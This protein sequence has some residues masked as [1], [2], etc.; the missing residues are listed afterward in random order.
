MSVFQLDLDLLETAKD[1]YIKSAEAL[2]ADIETSNTVVSNTTTE[3]YEGEDGE[4]FRSG[5]GNFVNKDFTDIGDTVK[6][7]GTALESGLEEGKKC[8]KICNDFLYTL[9]GTASGTTVEEMKGI[10][11]CDQSIITELKGF[12]STALEHNEAVRLGSLELDSIL[13]K[14]QMVSLN[15][16]QYTEII[17]E[18]CKKVERL[19]DHSAELTTYATAA[20]DADSGLNSYLS[21]CMPLGCL[22]A[23]L[24]ADLLSPQARQVLDTI[25]KPEGEW[26]EEDR[27]NLE[28]NLWILTE[29]GEITELEKIAGAIAASENDIAHT[30]VGYCVMGILLDYAERNCNK[31]I[32]D[33]L[34][35]SML[36]T[37]VVSIQPDMHT[38]TTFTTY[39]YELSFDSEIVSGILG[40]LDPEENGLAYYSLQR[41]SKYAG[42]DE[43]A[44]TVAGIYPEAPEVDYEISFEEIDGKMVSVI[45][46]G[47]EE[48]KL[49]SV[50]MNEI[51]GEEGKA[52]M[53]NEKGFSDEQ[54]VLFMSN[55]YTDED[56]VFVGDLASA[57]TD[58]DYKELFQNDPNKLSIHAGI[59]LHNY[60]LMLENGDIKYDEN[61]TITNQT[62][63]TLQE[64]IN[65]M[66][67]REAS[68]VVIEEQ[69]NGK[70]REVWIE[71]YRKGYL[72][73]MVIAGETQM[74]V[75]NYQMI[76]N[77]ANKDYINRNLGLYAENV[78][79][80]SLFATLEQRMQEYPEG[81]MGCYIEIS[82]LRLGNENTN[83]GEGTYNMNDVL[84]SYSE[85]LMYGNMGASVD[86]IYDNV[87]PISNEIHISKDMGK[88]IS[89]NIASSYY[90]E[91]EEQY[92][93]AVGEAAYMG[94]TSMLSSAGEVVVETAVGV[95]GWGEAINEIREADYELIEAKKKVRDILGGATIVYNVDECDLPQERRSDKTHEVEVMSGE[96]DAN[97]LLKMTTLK[98]EGLAG[99]YG[100]EEES[101]E[102]SS[103]IY[104]KATSAN[105]EMEQKELEEEY[106]LWT[107]TPLS[108]ASVIQELEDVDPNNV[109]NR[110]E[111]IT[112]RYDSTLKGFDYFN[113]NIIETVYLGG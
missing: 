110:I 61:M 84:F 72:D 21:L 63:P 1:E 57:K 54:I 99:V 38:N 91:K 31:E 25:N 22:D 94:V 30:E 60:A 19:E 106:L 24:A 27:K 41:R 3:V 50:D 55:I 83:A 79:L 92:K 39:T 95:A 88:D 9:E 48:V 67:Y 81:V 42:T 35:T 23:I 44:V 98:E 104:R 87:E 93:Y 62:A 78:Q 69:D 80:L 85:N 45:A 17:R 101:Q 113:Y 96:F 47:A 77:Y 100:N 33:K 73:L 75:L 107:G 40:Y 4:V 46:F 58:E 68:D 15:A 82:K 14:L 89:M 59:G 18:G 64:F 20:E 111:N 74:K 37:E 26:T 51:V 97:A 109:K 65:A 36:T 90:E 112:G 7:I 6:R 103:D 10:L 52:I 56:I 29:N 53:K 16:G 13:G 49:S 76:T 102:I 105:D 43:V 71:D 108:N 2:G 5:F 11:Y 86:E 8:K 32:L 28:K 70:M 34:Y 66:L 12:C